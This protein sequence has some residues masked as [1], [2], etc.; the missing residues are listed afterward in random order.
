MA[1][2]NGC[3]AIDCG[4]TNRGGNPPE[5][6]EQFEKC[7]ALLKADFLKLG[8]SFVSQAN[9]EADDIIAYLAENLDACIAAAHRIA[10]LAQSGF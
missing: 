7:K 5:M 8:A 4:K 1:I 2:G 10:D 3:L 9:V 6:Y